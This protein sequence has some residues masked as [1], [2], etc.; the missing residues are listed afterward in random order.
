MGESENEEEISSLPKIDSSKPISNRDS[1][2]SNISAIEMPERLEICTKFEEN[3]E[4]LRTLTKR[5]P[6]S[7]TFQHSC[8]SLHDKGDYVCMASG[9]KPPAAPRNNRGDNSP[10]SRL[11]NGI[12]MTSFSNP[13]TATRHNQAEFFAAESNNKD[14]SD[15]VRPENIFPEVVNRREILEKD[16]SSCNN[17][18]DTYNTFGSCANE[19]NY[20]GGSNYTNVFGGSKNLSDYV[21]FDNKNPEEVSRRGILRRDTSINNHSDTYNTIGSCADEGNY[22]GSSNYNNVYGG[23]NNPPMWPCNATNGVN[24]YSSIP[25]DQHNSG[26][27]HDD[28]NSQTQE[29]HYEAVNYA[30][31][32]EDPQSSGRSSK[33]KNSTVE[34]YNVEGPS[35]K[36]TRLLQI[37]DYILA[38]FLV[39]L[40]TDFWRIKKILKHHIEH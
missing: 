26:S 10:S 39:S 35:M 2:F 3:Q 19:G 5:R 36:L 1:I 12:K 14:L 29:H 17:H 21:R 27:V 8:P 40:T 38:L 7:F 32:I 23:T 28:V 9:K 33:D 31:L 6:K 15:Y 25:I 13:C 22:R 4:I 11:I 18:S 30:F 24:A 37:H 20:R 16:N 34:P